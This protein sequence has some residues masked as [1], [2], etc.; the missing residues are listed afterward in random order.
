METCI[1]QRRDR[2]KKNGTPK[3]PMSFLRSNSDYFLRAGGRSVQ[4]PL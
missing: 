1:P 4:T 2:L 3:G